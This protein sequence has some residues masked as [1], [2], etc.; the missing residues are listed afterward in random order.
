MKRFYQKLQN[1]VF[2]YIFL[3]FNFLDLVIFFGINSELQGTTIKHVLLG[4]DTPGSSLSQGACGALLISQGYFCNS[5]LFPYSDYQGLKLDVLLKAEE[6]SFDIAS[7]LLLKSIKKPYLESL[8]KDHDFLLYSGL[9]RFEAKYKYFSLSFIPFHGIAALKVSNPSLPEINASSFKESRVKLI[10]GYRF[11]FPSNSIIESFSLGA[12]LSSSSRTF[13]DFDTDVI[14]LSSKSLDDILVKKEENSFDMDIGLLMVFD[15]NFL[16]NLGINFI[17]ITKA[18]DSYSELDTYLNIFPYFEKSTEVSFGY[19][20]KLP[21]GIFNVGGMVPYQG[22]FKGLDRDASTFSLNYHLGHLDG[23]LSQSK[24][25]SSFGF[26]FSSFLYQVGIKYSN[27]K[28][29]NHVQLK[30]KKNVYFFTSLDL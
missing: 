19:S 9:A 18:D 3:S 2:K 13:I 26:I 23:F 10:S 21:Y 1:F 14:E 12:S 7:N 29:L 24:Y 6:K 4:K 20:L 11:S 22:I 30:R 5:A 28:Q 25:Q 8:F 15:R 27:E 17:N 16:P